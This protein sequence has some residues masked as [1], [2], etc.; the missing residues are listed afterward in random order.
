MKRA[1][2]INANNNI[3]YFAPQLGP[4]VFHETREK[5]GNLL[6]R[7]YGLLGQIIHFAKKKLE[8]LIFLFFSRTTNYLAIIF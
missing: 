6:E 8:H 4:I 1:G 2:A 7:K 5:F 3:E